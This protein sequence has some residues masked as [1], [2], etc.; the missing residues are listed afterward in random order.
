MESASEI[1]VI[2]VES[3]PVANERSTVDFPYT[4]LD[5]AVEVVRG[6]HNAGG[7]AC[8]SDQLAA[9]LNLEAKGGGFRLRIGGAKSFAL[10]TYERGGRVTLTDL[11]RQIIDP[12]LERT[13]RMSAFLAVELYQRVFDQF[14]GGPL[15]PQAGLER[16]LVSLGVGAGVKD[17]ARQVMLRSAKQS[18]FFEHA[19]DRLVKPAIRQEALPAA[20]DDQRGNAGSEI[21]ANN[22]GS[23]GGGSGGGGRQHPLIQ[24]LLMTLPEPGGAWAAEDRVNWLTMAGSIFKMIYTGEAGNIMITNSAKGGNSSAS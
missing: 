4:D 9:Q 15:P 18:G 22:G 10:I 8:D 7:T 17:R 13:A 16:A 24:G 20:K 6:V 12:H 21:A 3:S 2:P 19:A 23:G 1:K 5:S 11:G 14:K